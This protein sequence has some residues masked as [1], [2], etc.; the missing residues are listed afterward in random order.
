MVLTFIICNYL[1]VILHQCLIS[2]KE[3]NPL[4]TLIISRYSI[5]ET[6]AKTNTGLEKNEHTNTIYE[7]AVYR[8]GLQESIWASRR[9]RRWANYVSDVIVLEKGKIIGCINEGIIYFLHEAIVHDG[10]QSNCQSKLT[11]LW[12]RLFLKCFSRKL[13]ICWK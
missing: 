6:S 12:W 3:S 5:T 13:W 8:A 1:L 7:A 10:K 9:L 4:S 2:E 11:S